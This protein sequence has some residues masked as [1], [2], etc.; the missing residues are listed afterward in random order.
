M[1]FINQNPTQDLQQNNIYGTSTSGGINLNVPEPLGNQNPLINMGFDPLGKIKQDLT[2]KQLKGQMENLGILPKLQT[3]EDNLIKIL[4][5]KAEIAEQKAEDDLKQR[6]EREDTIRAETQ[7]REDN[8]YQRLVTDLKKAG[9]NPNLFMGSPSSG[10]GITTDSG[11][12]L[13][14]IEGDKERLISYI[15]LQ[16]RNDF[17]RGEKGKDRAIKLLD[18]LIGTGEKVGKAVMAGA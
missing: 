13:G 14:R 11:K 9:I 4:D 7:A 1:N 5:E 2:K 17:E 18:V 12:D 15:L 8:Q 6:W 3:K 16:I 10:G